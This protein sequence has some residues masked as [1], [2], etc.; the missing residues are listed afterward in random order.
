M[1]ELSSEE[2]DAIMETF[3]PITDVEVPAPIDMILHC[4]ECYVQHIDEPE[5]D[6]SVLPDGRESRWENPPHRSHLCHNCGTIWRPADVPTNGVAAIKTAGKADCRATPALPQGV[7]EAA[8][9]PTKGMNLG[10]R[11]KHVGGRENEA[12][13]IEFGSVMAVDAL[14]NHVLRDVLTIKAG[15]A[16]VPV[17]S[18]NKALHGLEHLKADIQNR[19]KL[20]EDYQEGVVMVGAGAWHALCSTILMLAAAKEKG[21]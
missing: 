10:E 12:G 8:R 19:S 6:A 20:Q 13:Y 9:S 15:M 21:D 5:S 3:G 4:P 7:E 2:N 17:E 14:I 11:I 1:T 16:I 18:I